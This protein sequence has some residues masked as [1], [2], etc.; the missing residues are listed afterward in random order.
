M[1]NEQSEQTNKATSDYGADLDIART[2]VATANHVKDAAGRAADDVLSV[3]KLLDVFANAG[4]TNAG[5][6]LDIHVVAEGEDDALD[7][8][9]QLARRR[10]DK[11]LR[12][13]NRGVDRL[14]SRNRERGSFSSSGLGLGNDV[15]ARDDGQNRPLLDGRR[16]LEVYVTKE[17]ARV[18]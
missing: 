2:K 5:M 11:G 3:V 8:G 16:L 7:L 1:I 10:K 18:S 17:K 15:A 9:R 4:A 12:L 14:E 6:A 13:T